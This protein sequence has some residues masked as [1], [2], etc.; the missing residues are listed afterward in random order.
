MI[1]PSASSSTI[2][3]PVE[4]SIEQ[5]SASNSDNMISAFI[6]GDRQRRCRGKQRTAEDEF[7]PDVENSMLRNLIL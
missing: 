6:S 2:R 3:D 1:S 5:G 7:G 4:L